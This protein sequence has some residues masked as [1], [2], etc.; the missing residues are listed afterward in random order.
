MVYIEFE[1]NIVEFILIPSQEIFYAENSGFGV[2]KFST[3]SKIDYTEKIIDPFD[4]NANPSWVGTIAGMT[5]KLEYGT[6]YK[7]KAVPELNSKYKN[8]QYKPE[9][10]VAVKPTT[11]EDSKIFLRACGISPK[12]TDE[13]IGTYPNLIDDIINDDLDIDAILEIK[14]IGKKTI[15]KIVDRVKDSFDSMEL[16]VFLNPLGIT[17]NMIRKIFNNLS[18]ADIKER[19]SKNPYELTKIN[20]LGFKRVDDIALKVNPELRSSMFRTK[21]YIIHMLGESANRD[22]HTWLDSESFIGKCRENIPE[23]K[24]FVF[25]ILKNKDSDYLYVDRENKRVGLK[26]YYDLEVKIASE[27][28]RI[29]CAESE[30][31]YPDFE[32][33]IKKIEDEQGWSFTDEQIEGIKLSFDHNIICI[34]GGAGT[35]KTSLS[36]AITKFHDTNGVAQVALAGKAALRIQEVNGYP[37]STIHR[38][39]DYF[40]GEFTRNKYN[41]IDEKFEIVD[42][43]SMIG[44]ELFYDLI[45]A[46]PTGAKLVIM[47]DINQLESIG[48]GSVFKDVLESEFIPVIKLTKIHRQAQKSAIITE[49]IKV[50][51]GKN[52]FPPNFLGTKILGELQDLELDIFL[53]KEE[54]FDSV[55]K[56]Y[57]KEYEGGESVDEIQI[58]VP[59]KE[60][61][62]A[63]TYR[64]NNAVQDL[65]NPSN[66]NK[67]EISLNLKKDLPYVLREGD[68]VLNVANQYD[69]CDINNKPTPVFNGNFGII[70]KIDD[71]CMLID[72]IGIGEVVFPKKI[73]KSIELGYA[74][75]VHKLQGSEFR[76]VI[77]GI[78]S[79]SYIMLS[80]EM[81]YTAMTRASK[82]CY[83]CG[84]NK[85]IKQCVSK[86][87]L[88]KKMTHLKSFLVKLKEMIEKERLL[89][90]NK[91]KGE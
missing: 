9:S 76:K 12:Q 6:K 74:A 15:D 22:G 77:V 33:T 57:K 18:T 68:K 11:P 26:Y 53:D 48:V 7:V 59:M 51:D 23:C 83:L 69:V 87:S 42:E 55:I 32:E 2:Y 52:I 3:D 85:A 64:L 81:L 62:G 82:K 88:S 19:I 70:K 65:V 71:A 5:G 21:A 91:L 10:V 13:L 58:V 30:F 66:P 45:Q 29:L 34:T 84:E 54:T 35:G 50:K 20:G 73:W 38:L 78:D 31:S 63:C 56:A 41:P 60:R 44:A 27:L 61:G 89:Q 1:N 4:S 17:F 49:S 14:G 79:S 40:M 36:T 39:L 86:S 75:T 16:T 25:E 67:K 46:V 43:A 80:K 28:L 37:S 90:E 47:G 24:D 72:F 8:W